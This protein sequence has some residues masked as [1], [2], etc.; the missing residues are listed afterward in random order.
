MVCTHNDNDMQ[1]LS[2]PDRWQISQRCGAHSSARCLDRLSPLDYG[3]CVRDHQHPHC[4]GG[5][6]CRS[7]RHESYQ[8]LSGA[9]NLSNNCHVYM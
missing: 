6:A 7:A 8:S 5:K 3:V 1:G 4:A 2:W 9:L